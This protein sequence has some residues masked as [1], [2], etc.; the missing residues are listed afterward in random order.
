MTDFPNL[1]QTVNAIYGESTPMS[2]L[3]F[4]VRLREGK[5]AGATPPIN[6][7]TN[8]IKNACSEIE[9]SNAC[10]INL[11]NANTI[12]LLEVIF[13]YPEQLRTYF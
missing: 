10:I 8:Y 3:L 1:Y 12:V 13:F 11:G 4:I 2:R 6:I 5:D 9:E 7:F